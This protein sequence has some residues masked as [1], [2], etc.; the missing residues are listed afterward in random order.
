M[1]DRSGAPDE[2]TSRLEDLLAPAA[3]R[4]TELS[5][6]APEP[7]ARIGRRPLIA[8]AALLVMGVSLAVWF[9]TR[10][11]E[12]WR[13]NTVAGVPRANGWKLKT[14]SVL[15]VG[16]W[17][18]TDS[19]SSAQVR[20]ASI[21]TLD[22]G[23]GSRLRIRETDDARHAVEL[24]H[25]HIKAT[26]TA[27]PKLF[28]VH[29]PAALATDMGCQYELTVPRDGPGLLRVTVGWVQLDPAAGSAPAPAGVIAARV[30][31][32][33]NCWID[34]VAGPGTPFRA[35]SSLGALVPGYD[36]RGWADLSG[37]ELAGFLDKVGGGDEVT[38]WHVL[39]RVPAAQRGVV[40]DSLSAVLPTK[41][42]PDRDA[43]L[44]LDRDTL[45]RVWDVVCA[46]G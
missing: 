34:P 12:G 14:G 17:L 21:G 29:T 42:P 43:L 30:P 28:F 38:L 16:A 36:A 10:T 40:I 20:V 24:D 18:E 25:G 22:V 1:W 4:S 45:E 33:V 15:R 44:R 3:L 5:D 13:V 11:P 9:G 7:M 23:S 41:V 31:R 32:G 35:E 26:I 37:V 46:G 39:Q 6:V 8:L 2:L 19:A 27:P